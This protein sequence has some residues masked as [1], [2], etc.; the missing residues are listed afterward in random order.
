MENT[1]HCEVRDSSTKGSNHR[2]RNN[3][4]VPGVIYG[5]NGASVNVEFGELEFFH[6]LAEIGQYGV[7]EIDM[8]GQKEKT[9]IKELQRHPTSRRLMHVDLQRVD[10]NKKVHTHIPILYM[11]AETLK[12]KDTI[13]QPQ[14]DNVEIEC[15]PDKLPKYATV[16]VTNMK[17]G[18]KITYNDLELSTEISIVGDKNTIIAT[19]S[20]LRSNTEDD[21][22]KDITEVGDYK[23]E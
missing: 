2:L 7:V 3:G 6:N 17:Q 19:I 5:L 15:V 22:N 12:Q 21:D 18:R 10:T 23:V 1:I 20:R 9:I 4:K 13:V 8:N 11:G 16:N 14:I